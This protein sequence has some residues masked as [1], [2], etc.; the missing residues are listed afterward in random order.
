MNLSWGGKGGRCV[1]LTTL[2]PSCADCLKNLGASSSWIPKGLPRPV[3]GLLCFLCVRHLCHT[4]KKPWISCYQI[5]VT[6]RLPKQPLRKVGPSRKI[7]L[8]LVT[9]LAVSYRIP[10]G[11]SCVVLN[12]GV[13]ARRSRKVNVTELQSAR[14]PSLYRRKARLKTWLLSSTCVLSSSDFL[15]SQHKVQLL[16]RSTF[17]H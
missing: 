5:L 11:I 1:G 7:K 16:K 15:S 17:L 3:K 2:P 14:R 8:T 10:V 12:A 13:W 9:L 6:K 4:E